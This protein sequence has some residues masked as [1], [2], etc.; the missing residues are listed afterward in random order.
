MDQPCATLFTGCKI[1]LLGLGTWKSSQNSVR[2]AV[3]CAVLAGY[4]HIDCAWA[5]KNEAEVGVALGE[6]MAEGAVRREELFI[7]SKLWNS[8]HRSAQDLYV[9]T[10]LIPVLAVEKEDDT[11]IYNCSVLCSLPEEDVVLQAIY[12]PLY[13]LACHTIYGSHKDGRRP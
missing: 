4:R 3:R 8:M 6:L 1:P 7:T 2:D 11:L 9:P 5:Y 10:C 13:V 12:A